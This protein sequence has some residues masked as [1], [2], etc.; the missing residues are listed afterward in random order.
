MNSAKS[1]GGEEGRSTARSRASAQW[2]PEARAV[3]SA[4]TRE[5]MNSPTVRRKVAE[6]TRAA[7]S[8]RRAWALAAL[9]AAWALTDKRTR[10]VFLTEVIGSTVGE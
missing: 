8:A 5:R 7:H 2:T 4:L 3:Q 1:G 9:R 6:G 10:A